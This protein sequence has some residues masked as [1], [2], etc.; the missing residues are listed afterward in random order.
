MMIKTGPNRDALHAH[1]AQPGM[2]RGAYSV[3]VVV[4]GEVAGL[5][6]PTRRL[7]ADSGP[8]A[9]VPASSDIPETDTLKSVLPMVRILV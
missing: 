8:P 4:R 9:A 7:L 1:T 6:T 3:L 2:M 5:S